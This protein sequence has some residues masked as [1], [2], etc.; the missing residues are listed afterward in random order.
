LDI[1]RKY[2]SDNEAKRSSNVTTG[3]EKIKIAGK[4]RSGLRE[5]AAGVTACS[6]LILKSNLPLIYY[7]TAELSVDTLLYNTVS[8]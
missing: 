1:K 7:F 8:S 6:H 2:K 3:D 4:M 5:A